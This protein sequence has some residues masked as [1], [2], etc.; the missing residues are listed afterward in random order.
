MMA[1]LNVI[2][3]SDNDYFDS[4]Y[5]SVYIVAL[6]ILGLAAIL[7]FLF[8][9]WPNANLPR[10]F[11][12]P[13]FLLGLIANVFMLIWT[14][15]Y[16]TTI[17]KYDKAYVQTYDHD[18][19]LEESGEQKPAQRKKNYQEESKQFYILSHCIPIIIFIF[20]YIYAFMVS[21]DWKR[22]HRNQEYSF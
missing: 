21:L 19:G 16:M 15:V 10:S 1:L 3:I 14:I 18:S 2:Q 5:L 17:Y 13:A 12:P 22:R 8:L 20:F 4:I 7:A 6:C 9:V 11:L